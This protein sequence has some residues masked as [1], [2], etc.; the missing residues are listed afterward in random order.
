MDNNAPRAWVSAC[1]RIAR[2]M[3]R[4]LALDPAPQL[5]AEVCMSA[6]GGMAHGPTGRHREPSV[7]GACRG[8]GGILALAM[9]IVPSRMDPMITENTAK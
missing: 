7:D 2:A 6:A 8:A 1:A 4:L 9:T 5:A 3:Q